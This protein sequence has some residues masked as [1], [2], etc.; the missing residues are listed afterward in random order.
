MLHGR[1]PSPLMTTDVPLLAQYAILARSLAVPRRPALIAGLKKP[2]STKAAS[3]AATTD[4]AMPS[5]NCR[6]PRLLNVE[7]SSVAPNDGSGLSGTVPD[8][9][10]QH[11]VHP[12]GVA[13]HDRGR[14]FD[15]ADGIRALPDEC[16]ASGQP[17]HEN[18]APAGAKPRAGLPGR[19]H[20]AASRPRQA[21]RDR[22]GNLRS[23]QASPR[24]SVWL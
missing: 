9:H 22:E 17:W 23:G 8:L 4:A 6:V 13:A 3:D 16:G 10:N 20:T 12:P 14:G 18:G 24:L 21:P 1:A 11:L 19:P 5:P 7:D 15:V 2:R